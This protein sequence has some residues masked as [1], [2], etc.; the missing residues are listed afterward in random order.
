MAANAVR[1]GRV[2]RLWQLFGYLDLTWMLR[3]LGSFAGYV[4]S[5]LVGVLAKFFAMLLLAERFDGIG[6]WGNAQIVFLL[7]FAA[8]VTGTIDTLFGYNVAFISRRIGRGQLDHVLVQ[9][10]PLWLTLLT[11]GFSPAA[12]LPVFL[13]GVALL[14]RAWARLPLVLSA[15]W[16]ALFALNLLA[17]CV[18]LLAFSYAV[19]SVAFWAPRAAEEINSS[20]WRLIGQL[21]TFPLDGVGQRLLGGLLT[22]VPAGFI[23]WYPSRALLGLEAAPVGPYVTPLA[24]LVFGLVALAIFRTG[25]RHY[26]HTGSQRYLS[27]GHRR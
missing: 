25:L 4:F 24:A 6:P 23:A 9:P 7:G 26:A 11:E 12:G 21:R 19:G 16:L 27:Y 15:G 20:T 2:L 13:S 5:E 10:Q 3:D 14:V 1:P 22:V 17:A 8:M 18:I